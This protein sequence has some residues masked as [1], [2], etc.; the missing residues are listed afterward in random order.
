MIRERNN[1][2]ANTKDHTGM[3]FAMSVRVDVTFFTDIFD[4]HSDHRH[5]FFIDCY[6]L[7]KTFL[8]EVIKLELLGDN[9]FNCRFPDFDSAIFYNK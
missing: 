2:G 1:G 8:Y 7:D 3:D 5:F 9:S 4:V 6:V